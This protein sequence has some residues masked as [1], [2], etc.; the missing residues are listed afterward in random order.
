MDSDN[1]CE[2]CEK[3][4]DELVTRQGF[5]QTYFCEFVCHDCFKKLEGVSFED[6]SEV[7]YYGAKK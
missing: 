3:Q 6:Y 4:F 1:V 5:V 7:N 2:E